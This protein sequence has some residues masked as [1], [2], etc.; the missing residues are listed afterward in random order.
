MCKYYNFHESDITLLPLPGDSSRLAKK[1]LIKKRIFND[2]NLDASIRIILHSG[3]LPGDKET[4]S[5]IESF[6]KIKNIN[7]RLILAGSVSDSF[8][9]TLDQYIENDKR[10]I[11]MG[12]VSASDLRDLM[13]ASDLLVQPG[14]LSNSFIDAI[15]CGLPLILDD[16]PQGRYLTKNENGVLIARKNLKSLAACIESC[17]EENKNNLLKEN[18]IKQADFYHYV[19]IARISLS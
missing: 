8:R 7:L 10:I 17:L 12:W 11:E 2:L 14:S 9:S 19:N 18:S 16:T 3:K 13:L 15:C 6:G 5:V 4:A 1:D